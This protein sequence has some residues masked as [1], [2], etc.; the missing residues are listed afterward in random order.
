VRSST[1]SSFAAVFEVPDRAESPAADFTAW[2]RIAA[3]ATLVLGAACQVVAFLTIPQFSS[4]ADRLQWIADNEARA[5]VS[6]TFDVLAMPFLFGSIL[7]YVLLARRRSPRLAY[8]G[9]VAFGCGMIG[10][11]MVN[12]IEVLEFAVAQDGRFSIKALADLAD[13]VST[14]PAI[15]VFV[16]FIPGAFFGLLLTTIALWRSRAVPR[17]AVVLLPIFFVLDVP[18]QLGDIAHVIALVA[19][20]WFAWAILTAP[21]PLN[22][23]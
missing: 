23:S 16:L 13:N 11:S 6:K 15:A 8:A 10:L 7:V 21:K 1:I 9:G 19:A 3:A 17:G 22:G 5:N 12:G 18:L 4:T 14:A 2:G 20:A